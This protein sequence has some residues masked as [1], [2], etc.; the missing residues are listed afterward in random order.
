[1]E[2]D[3]ANDIESLIR[4]C[5]DIFSRPYVTPQT[6]A[7]AADDE[8]I[9]KSID[10]LNKKVASQCRARFSPNF[11]SD[12]SQQT[13][14]SLRRDWAEIPA[15]RKA[16]EEALCKVARDDDAVIATSLAALRKHV[17]V[18]TRSADTKDADGDSS[19]ESDIILSIDKIA[20][21]HAQIAAYSP[22][23]DSALL[24]DVLHFPSVAVSKTSNVCR[25]LAKLG[26][27]LQALV[28]LLED[29]R[30]LDFR[31]SASRNLKRRREA[32]I[33][34]SAPSQAMDLHDSLLLILGKKPRPAV[35]D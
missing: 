32:V 3:T 9:A 1:M 23:L 31:R 28:S 10:V 30:R 6:N 7:D 2:A 4:R 20:L 17:N 34:E 18:L 8:S 19:M 11:V 16:A 14:I 15:E 22:L 24:L 29:S 5:N 13:L 35:S 26:E 27:L 25:Q 21:L 12:L 33:S